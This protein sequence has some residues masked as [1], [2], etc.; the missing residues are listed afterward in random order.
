MLLRTAL[1]HTTK[2]KGF[3]EFGD[4]INFTSVMIDMSSQLTL[5]EVLQDLHALEASGEIQ[6]E[7]MPTNNTMP[8]RI[9]FISE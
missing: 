2:E 6:V 5:E 1:K 9:K 7:Y 4:F 3:D 8:W